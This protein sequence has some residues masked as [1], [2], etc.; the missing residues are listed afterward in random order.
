MLRPVLR[1]LLL[2][3][4]IAGGLL[5]LNSAIFHAWAA[6]VPPGLYPEIHRSIA[7]KHLLISITMF[8]LSVLS[9][10]L[11]KKKPGTLSE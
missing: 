6:D 2:V 5:F 7:G 3:L 10:W 1:W 9:L 4:F 8:C 11:V